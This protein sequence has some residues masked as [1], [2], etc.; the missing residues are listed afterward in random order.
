MHIHNRAMGGLGA[1]PEAPL[2]Q[3]A[4]SGCPD[5]LNA[6]MIRHDGLVQVSVR[7]QV[8]GNLPFAEALQAGRIGLWR[9]VPSTD[10][11]Q[12]WATTRS[13]ARPS[14]PTPGLALCVRSGE[15]SRCIPVSTRLSLRLSFARLR[16]GS[17]LARPFAVLRAGS[18]RPRR[19]GA[20]L[21]LRPPPAPGGL[22]SPPPC[23]GPTAGLDLRPRSGTLRPRLHLPAHRLADHQRMESDPDPAQPFG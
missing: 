11:G 12:A 23:A 2:F 22:H 18:R 16:T 21:R 19:L 8:L 7:R 6:L 13:A 1:L 5:S 9:A 3:R 17:G 15:R 4:Q 14:P 20:P 10:S